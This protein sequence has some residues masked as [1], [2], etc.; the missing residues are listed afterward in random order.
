MCIWLHLDN[1]AASLV[2]P[3]WQVSIDYGQPM[4]NADLRPVVT[5][6]EGV[7]PPEIWPFAPISK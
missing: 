6:F 7:G 2:A 3:L 4:L 5:I 1:K